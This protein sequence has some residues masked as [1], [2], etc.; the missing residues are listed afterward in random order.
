MIS[1]TD[2]QT[3]IWMARIFETAKT[4][5]Q[6]KQLRKLKMSGKL[7]SIGFWL[8]P[9]FD[10]CWLYCCSCLDKSSGSLTFF[11]HHIPVS[12]TIKVLLWH[13]VLCRTPFL[14]QPSNLSRLWTAARGHLV[15]KANILTPTPLKGIQR[16]KIFIGATVSQEEEWVIS[17]LIPCSSSILPLD[18]CVHA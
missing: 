12:L 6:K 15:S 16:S 17:G 1:N 10:C 4:N 18:E 13:R 3:H 11:Y 8:F 14:M 7:D 5:K 2:T 9:T